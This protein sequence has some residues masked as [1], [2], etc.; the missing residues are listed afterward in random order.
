VVDDV[1]QSGD[2][3]PSATICEL[4]DFIEDARRDRDTGGFGDVRK[5]ACYKQVMIPAPLFST[6]S[7]EEILAE[8]R[9]LVANERAATAAL[10]QSLMEVDSRRLYLREGC[11]SLF[12]YCTQVLRLAEG[13]AYNRI[14]AA[15]A[16]RR[17]PIALTAL[18]E[19]SVTLTTIRL[20]A[21]HLTEDNHRAL[22]AQAHHKSKREVELLIA[23]L[24]PKPPVVTIVRKLPA[25]RVV[26]PTSQGLATAATAT[27][28]SL[29]PERSQILALLDTS[30]AS[31]DRP[32]PTISKQPR[33]GQP[34]SMLSPLSVDRYK[35]QVTISHDT[36][37]K[38]RRAQD[39]LRHTTPAG[40]VATILDRALTL[41]LADLE[42]RRCAAT[43]APRA[44]S[45]ATGHTRYI[46]A[47]VR[48]E[49]WRRDQGRCAFVGAAGRCRETGF[50][51]FH[52]VEPYAD[53]GAATIA[54]IQL[55]C[56]AHNLY[57]ASL[58]G[59]DGNEC[60]RER[61]AAGWCG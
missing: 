51:E 53:G 6:L 30:K 41:L 56:R 37:T 24:H 58:F 54:N 18:A 2:V 35:L 22:L 27:P 11:S 19:G 14:E 59:R 17:Y 1:L 34:V 5:P 52:H 61:P 45:T 9:R 40:D 29:S 3:A 46:P 42:H 25:R 8:T 36:H 12:T 15:R 13:A 48:R 57:E 26:P 20:L 55:R 32:T 23:A 7:D 38:L 21:P 31:S 43:P 50:L 16:G 33:E 47:A 44:V 49:V 28:I 60:V 10:L 39:L 4:A